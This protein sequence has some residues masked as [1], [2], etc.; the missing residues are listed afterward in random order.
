MAPL[1]WGIASAGKIS[2]DFCAALSTYSQDDHQ[3]VAVAA[4]SLEDAKE[5]A[6]TFN[7]PRTHEGYQKLAQDPEVDVVYIGSINTTHLEIGLMMLDGGKHILCEKPLTLNVKQAE[8]LLN[9]A[10]EKKL[11]CME[12]IWSRYFPIYRQLKARINNG[13]LG[14]IKEVYAEFGVEMADVDRVMKNELGGGSTLDIGTYA[15]QFS[16]FV[17]RAEPTSIKA[18]GKLNEEGVDTETEVELKYPNGGVARY[19]TNSTKELSNIATVTGSKGTMKLHTFWCPTEL[20]D[21]D[22]QMKKFELPQNRLGK[23][24]YFHGAGM[25]YEAEEVRRCINEGLTESE[26]ATHND[27]L[28]IARIRDEIRRQLGVKFDED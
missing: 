12:A 15:I 23:F 7:I 5:F 21:V 9:H 18:T 22:G 1:R 20:E 27:S 19:K 6:E 25:R 16:Q 8:Q 24:I 2:N 26:D 10:K 28:V 3:V 17:F 4:R 11:F 14:D 13:D